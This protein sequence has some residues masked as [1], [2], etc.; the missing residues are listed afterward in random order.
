MLAGADLKLVKRIL[1]IDGAIDVNPKTDA[2]QVFPRGDRRRRKGAFWVT[3]DDVQRLIGHDALKRKL[4]GY[5]VTPSLKRRLS[6]TRGPQY[7]LEERDVFIPSG[8]IR[9]A[10]VNHRSSALER[11]AR[12]RGRDGCLILSA[13]ELEAGRH[14]A[15]DYAMAGAGYVS[16]QNYDA[17]IVDG[18]RR[19]DAQERKMLAHMT[20]KTRLL[21]AREAMG[22]GI[23]RGVISLCCRDENLDA[24]ERAEKWAKSSGLTIVKIGLA[25]LVKLYGTQAGSSHPRE[26]EPHSHTGAPH[27]RRT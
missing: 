25:R 9:M 23:E 1:T 7:E 26:A 2:L 12:R 17:P 5:V 6:A 10:T 20:A 18:S 4:R 16:T 21:A 3:Q 14:L 19:R 13:A 11:L 22:D 24:V 15:R 27:G 8:V